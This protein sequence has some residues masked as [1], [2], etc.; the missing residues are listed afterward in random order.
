[1]SPQFR[2]P[3]VRQLLNTGLPGN[4]LLLP[5]NTVRSVVR[6][7]LIQQV[8]LLKQPLVL[9]VVLL[10]QPAQVLPPAGDSEEKYLSISPLNI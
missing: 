9:L 4:V 2:A 3:D 7:R 6:H 1:M 10:P 8:E 5:E